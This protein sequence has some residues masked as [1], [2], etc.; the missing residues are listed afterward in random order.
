MCKCKSHTQRQQ[1]WHDVNIT[2]ILELLIKNS[3]QR[4]LC[5][6]TAGCVLNWVYYTS[7]VNR[8]A[9]WSSR[10]DGSEIQV[11][12]VCL[13]WMKFVYAGEVSVEERFCLCVLIGRHPDPRVSTPAHLSVAA[14]VVSFIK[15][16][17]EPKGY[18][19]ILSVCLCKYTEL[20]KITHAI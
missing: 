16:Q 14:V 5:L 11:V 1:K 17:N 3:I 4:T 12:S 15:I 2:I 8:S 7:R 20:F 19:R 13:K 6:Q 18:E 9:R 10:R